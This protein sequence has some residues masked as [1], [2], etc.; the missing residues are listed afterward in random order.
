VPD[1]KRRADAKELSATMERLSGE[2]PLLWG[3]SIVGFGH[4]RYKYESGHGGEMPRIGFAPRARELVLYLACGAPREQELIGRLGMHRASK[5]CLYVKSLDDVDR[6][7]LEQLIVEAL[8]HMRRA[9][10]Q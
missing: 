7:V 2:P 1:P 10:P 4:C 5:A 9:Y 3:P 6:G 8:D